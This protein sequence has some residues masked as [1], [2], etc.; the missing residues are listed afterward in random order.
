[1]ST[2][3]PRQQAILHAKEILAKN[4]ALDIGMQ[5]S[6]RIQ[7]VTNVLIKKGVCTAEEIEQA[8]MAVESKSK[9]AT[10]HRRRGKKK[11]A[12]K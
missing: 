5:A 10:P 3:T 11:K 6:N 12:L 2:F 7:A 4:Y 9:W 1:M 8:W